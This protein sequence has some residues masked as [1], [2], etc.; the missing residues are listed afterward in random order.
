MGT[1]MEPQEVRG[2]RSHRLTIPANFLVAENCDNCCTLQTLLILEPQKHGCNLWLVRKRAEHLLKRVR[3]LWARC[4][5]SIV[6]GNLSTDLA[7]QRAFTGM[8][9]QTQMVMT[10]S[11]TRQIVMAKLSDAA[12]PATCF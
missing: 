10:P 9:A 2:H 4:R 8:R 5:Q 12:R 1:D 6:D 3:E 11:L 7:I